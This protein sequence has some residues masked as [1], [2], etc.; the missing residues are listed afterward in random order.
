MAQ[1]LVWRIGLVLLACW[2]AWVDVVRTASSASTSASSTI[3]EDDFSPQ[4]PGWSFSS[5]SADFLGEL[6]DTINVSSVTLTVDAASAGD[7]KVEFDLFSFRSLDDATSCCTDVLTLVGNGDVLFSG[8][9][10]DRGT[11]SFLTNPSGATMTSASPIPGGNTRRISVPVTL[12]SGSNVFTWSYSALQDIADEAWGL[13]N[14]RVSADD[15]DEF[16]VNLTSFIPGNN[17]QAPPPWQYRCAS[18]GA[19]F[20]EGDTRT[21]DPEATSFRTRQIVTVIPDASIDADGIKNSEPPENLTGLTRAYAADALPILDAGDD[22]GVLHDCSL[23]HDI[24]HASNSDM[25]VLVTRV[26]PSRI[27]VHFIGSAANPLVAAAAPI[28]W[29]LTLELDVAGSSPTWRLTGV[30][31]GFPAFEMYINN[32]PIYQRN[33]P[34]PYTFGGDL[35]KLFAHVGDVTVALSG[36]L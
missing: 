9:F 25:D 13:D 5:P 36:N 29:D 1:R 31:D 2:C 11:D 21:F 32:V 10:G 30:E 8:A 33:A 27:A 26:T 12:V 4:Q 6:N 7:G 18:R 28:D 22:D 16:R 35:R 17:L 14:V 24:G 20:F 3:F 19:L 15:S 23:L 34:P